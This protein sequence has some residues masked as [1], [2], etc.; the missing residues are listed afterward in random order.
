MWPLFLVPP[1]A[2]KNTG[3]GLVQPTAPPPTYPLLFLQLTPALSR[4]L[5]PLISLAS[6]PLHRS[7]FL[8]AAISYLQLE[9]ILVVI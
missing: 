8:S 5:G 3:P 1:H 6:P 7:R 9:C 2:T 4:S